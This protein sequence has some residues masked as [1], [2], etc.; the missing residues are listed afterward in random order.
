ML[1]SLIIIIP[2][3]ESFYFIYLLFDIYK[4]QLHIII[5]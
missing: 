5:Y 1:V 2:V 3:Y 4:L